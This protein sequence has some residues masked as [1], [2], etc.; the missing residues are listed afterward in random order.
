M[1]ATQLTVTG[2][3][4]AASFTGDGA[5]LTNVG[6]DT[7]TVNTGALKVSGMTLT[8]VVNAIG[9]DVENKGVT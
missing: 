9:T 1:C 4:T 3:V 6:V 8:G 7:A 5:N 2:V